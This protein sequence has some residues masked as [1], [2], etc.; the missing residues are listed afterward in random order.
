[1]T[2]TGVEIQAAL[3]AELPDVKGGGR[4]EDI[5]LSMGG[6]LVE[7][8]LEKGR[9]DAESDLAEPNISTYVITD[10]IEGMDERA[11]LATVAIVH[12]EGSDEAT[13]GIEGEN[14][15]GELLR[16]VMSRVLE[17]ND[18]HLGLID[19]AN[20]DMPT[21]SLEDAGFRPQPGKSG[22]YAIKA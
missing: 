18:V 9:V 10:G 11:K 3:Q 1:M 14:T 20:V 21:E 17:R 5:R 8:V 2:G 16:K 13:I 6:A 15:N 12:E 22:L 7:F 19:P 4:L